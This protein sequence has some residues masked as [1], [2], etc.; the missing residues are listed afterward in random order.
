MEKV[1]MKEMKHF[2]LGILIGKGHHEG[3]EALQLGDSHWKR[4]S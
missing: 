2:S 4:S 3:D 1:I